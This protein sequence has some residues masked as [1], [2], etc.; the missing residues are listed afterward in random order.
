MLLTGVKTDRFLL[1]HLCL[2]KQSPLLK[3]TTLEFQILPHADRKCFLLVHFQTI[4]VQSCFTLPR[5]ALLIGFPI[6]ISKP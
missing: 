6:T 5:H 4:D 3:N 2:S 1:K